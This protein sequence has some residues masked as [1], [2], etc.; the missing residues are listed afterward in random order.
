MDGSSNAK[1]SG[2][3]IVLTSLEGHVFEYGVR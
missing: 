1:G 3:G 2:T